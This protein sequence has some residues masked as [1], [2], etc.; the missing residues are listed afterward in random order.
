MSLKQITLKAGREK[1]IHQRHP[2]VFSGAIDD[3][4]GSPSIGETV[5]IMSSKGEHLGWGAYSPFSS[6]RVRVWSFDPDETINEEFLYHKIL[7]ATKLREAL[8]IHE[9]SDAFRLIFGESDGLPGL[10]VDRYEDIAVMQIIS[11]GAEYWREVIITALREITHCKTIVERSDVEVRTLEGLQIREG[12]VWG[13]MPPQRL[14]IWENGIKYCVDVIGGQ[15]TGFYLDQRENRARIRELAKNRDVL[16]AFCYT[17]GFTLSAL[18]GGANSVISID[19]SAAALEL[20]DENLRLNGLNPQQNQWIE[21]DVFRELRALRD[22]ARKFDLIILDPP[23][24]APTAAQ[25]QKAARAYKDINLLGFKLLQRGG[26][27][28][29]F[30]CSGGINRELFQKIVADA[31]LDAGVDAKII[32]FLSQSADHPVALNFPESFY[33]KGLICVVS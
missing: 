10:I 17:G 21:G 14:Q 23:K 18:M 11:A 24:F 27:L 12:V 28:V 25:A 5:A 15:K 33:L 31:A 3:V 26:L 8:K 13:V 19:S 6:I 1:S 4:K 20:A 16:N 30:S 2:W 29:T 7:M 32:E 9:K 22:R